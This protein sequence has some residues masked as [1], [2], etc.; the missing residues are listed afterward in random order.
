MM[1]TAK[2]DLTGKVFGRL[3]VLEQTEDYINPQ[4]VH[5]RKW[6]CM[7]E[8]GNIKSIRETALKRG[9]TKSCGC[10]QK[11]TVANTGHANRKGNKY[12]LLNDY[13]ILWTTNTNEE[14]YFDLD[15]AN[16]ILQ[17]T[18]HED[19]TGYARANI[20]GDATRMHTFLGYYF[21]DHHNRNRLDNRRKNLIP[22]TV[23]ENNRNSSMRSDNTSGVKGISWDKKCQKWLSYIKLDD[24][25]ERLGYFQNI[26]DA[27]K[28]RLIAEAKYFKEFAPQRHLFE[29]YGI[30]C[31]S[32]NKIKGGD[33]ND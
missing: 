9:E 32:E 1:K 27:I 7:C 10:L 21:P 13:G 26:D 16:R 17:F 31:N 29:Q 33:S 6:L 8:C 19:A 2:E 22:C 25:F 3:T 4:G 5:Y 12:L 30:E 20:N 23:Q 14:V 18:W 24:K 28:T 11:E 15:D